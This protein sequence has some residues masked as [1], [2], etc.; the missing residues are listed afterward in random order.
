M[1][2][3]PVVKGYDPQVTIKLLYPYPVTDP[4]VFWL[5]FTT[6]RIA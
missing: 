1:Q 2:G 4:A 6:D 5:Y 3:N